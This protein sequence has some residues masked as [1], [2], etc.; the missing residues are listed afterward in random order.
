MYTILMVAIYSVAACSFNPVHTQSW[1]PKA[2]DNKEVYFTAVS[3]YLS[4]H[5][6]STANYINQGDHQGH[7]LKNTF[8]GLPLFDRI[9]NLKIKAV[10][11]QY[12]NSTRDF[13]IRYRK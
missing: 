1:N 11:S 6:S 4:G 7:N 13:P 3:S 12:S 9:A 10:Y 8:E 5:V 2:V